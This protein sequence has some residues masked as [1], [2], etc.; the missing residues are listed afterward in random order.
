NQTLADRRRDDR[1]G[2]DQQLRAGGARE[3]L[4]PL[5]TERIAVGAGRE[6][7]QAVAMGVASPGKQRRV[8]G[9]KL[10][11]SLDVVV[12]D[13]AMRLRGG[14]IESIAEALVHFRGEVLPTAESVRARDDELRVALRQWRLETRQVF[15]RT[16]DGVDVT[17]G[18]VPRELFR[19]FAE[20]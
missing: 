1:A 10:L 15:A 7:Q 8:F 17:G 5:L 12:V 3:P 4:L 2:V 9:Q 13:R 6:S 14:P 11:Q 20:R 18:D 19:L 16:R